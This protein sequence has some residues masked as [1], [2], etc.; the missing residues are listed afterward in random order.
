MR[1]FRLIDSAGAGAGADLVGTTDYRGRE[2]APRGGDSRC[3]Q[4]VRTLL[5][6]DGV[7]EASISVN[8]AG[9]FAAARRP[10]YRMAES[11]RVG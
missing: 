8:Y 11:G 3:D 6:V 9:H 10:Q 2:V 4:Q 1:R 7:E 5:Y